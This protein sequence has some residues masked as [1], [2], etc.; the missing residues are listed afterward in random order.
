[1]IPMMTGTSRGVS[2]METIIEYVSYILFSFSTSVGL[3]KPEDEDK[4]ND[5]KGIVT[6]PGRRGK[7]RSY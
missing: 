4:R 3:T 7:N 5:F 2:N 6:E 1:M